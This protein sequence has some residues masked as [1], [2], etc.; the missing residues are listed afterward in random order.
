MREKMEPTYEKCCYFCENGQVSEDGDSVFCKK[1]KKD[2]SP[3]GVCRAFFYDLLR[4]IPEL[5]KLPEVD[6]PILD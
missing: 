4:C 6:L 1:K 3:D 5:P 2:V